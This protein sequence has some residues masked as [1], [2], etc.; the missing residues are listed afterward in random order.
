MNIDQINQGLVDL[1]NSGDPY[2]AEAASYVS[3]LVLQVQNGEL[4]AAD[5]AELLQDVQRQLNIIEQMSQLEFKQKLN[6]LINGLIA[7]AGAVR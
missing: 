1:A 2:F 5:M 3:G 4:P 7:L 6:V